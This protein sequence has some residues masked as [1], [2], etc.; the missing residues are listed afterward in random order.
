MSS[1]LDRITLSL[2]SPT[3]FAFSFP[4]QGMSAVCLYVSASSLRLIVERVRA[5]TSV[6]P[7]RV[8]VRGWGNGKRSARIERLPFPFLL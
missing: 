7:A 6:L 2:S 3:F 5:A 4:S 8:N 1:R